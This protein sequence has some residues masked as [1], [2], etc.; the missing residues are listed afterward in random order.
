MPPKGSRK[1]KPA[2]T[3]AAPEKKA[4]PAAKAPASRKRK[5]V[6]EDLAAVEHAS[7]AKVSHLELTVHRRCAVH[8]TCLSKPLLRAL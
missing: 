5:P 4:N 8:A 2:T 1:P 7:H 6:D 3:Q